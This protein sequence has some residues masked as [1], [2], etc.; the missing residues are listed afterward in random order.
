MK[1]IVKF[2]SL[3]LLILALYIFPVEV[4]AA[5]ENINN[6]VSEAETQNI[7]KQHFKEVFNLDDRTYKVSLTKP[8]Y[9]INDE[10]IANYFE[11][12]TNTNEHYFILISTNLEYS[13]IFASGEDTAEFF[14]LN[15][16]A[17]KYYFV[18]GYTLIK[19]DN[20]EELINYVSQK[21]KESSLTSETM[22]KESSLTSEIKESLKLQKNPDRLKESNLDSV[23]VNNLNLIAPTSIGNPTLS[24]MRYSQYDSG[25]TSSYQKSA[26]GPT[27]MAVILQYWHDSRSKTN[28]KVYNSGYDSQGAFV[29]FLYV[30]RGGLFLGM[31]A[32][33]IINNLQ[34]E[35][36]VRGYSSTSSSFNNFN[37]YINEIEAM[38]PVAIKFDTYF[39][40]FEPNA[41]YAFD[42]HW[43]PGHGYVNSSSLKMLTVQTLDRN[44]SIKNFDYTTN[45]PIITM[46]KFNIQ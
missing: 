16:N 11:I 27:T 1:K 13:S 4:N 22:T 41:N 7:L 10:I 9:D 24:T 26:C 2:I 36:T 8:V 17:T 32:S 21:K 23:N 37:S 30:N 40:L 35:A 18:G 3:P 19:A 33:G 38:R 45:S 6:K 34:Y 43:T 15:E 25:I 12:R 28:L 14:I 42:Y 29:N 5:E 20:S 46:V 31:S 39:T 44:K